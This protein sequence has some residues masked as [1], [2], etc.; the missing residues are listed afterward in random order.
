MSLRVGVDAGKQQLLEL[1]GLDPV[2]RLRRGD[3]ALLDHV[4][5]DPH[6]CL[7][8]AF[9]RARLEH[10][11]LAALDCELE[12]LDVPVVLLELAR[13]ALELRVHLGQAALQSPDRLR[14]A[15]PRD[16]I[17]TLSVRKVVAIELLASGDWVACECDTCA[18]GRAHVA[19][20]HHLYVHRRP[21][22]VRNPLHPPVGHRAGSVPGVEDGLD[23][24]LQLDQGIRRKL[25]PGRVLIYGE[26]AAHQPAELRRRQLGIGLDASPPLGGGQSGFELLSLDAL[27]GL[28]EHLDEAAMG[29]E[30]ESLVLREPRQP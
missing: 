14:V 26:E 22:V 4:D 16:H 12:V 29:I 6:G 24:L 13:V 2:D 28:A 9:G 18:G 21:Q 11:E 8:G 10:E 30:R 15:H 5:G 20:G 25:L 7:A 3:Q 19:E 27:H 23:R 1:A 17:L